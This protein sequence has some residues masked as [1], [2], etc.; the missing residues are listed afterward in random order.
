MHENKR[1]E[2]RLVYC[3]SRGLLSLKH[4]MK[5][6]SYTN[7]NRFVER[8]CS[9]SLMIDVNGLALTALSI[10]NSCAYTILFIVNKH[11]VCSQ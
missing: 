8:E 3:F 2:N 5:M 9:S 11:I 4:R 10:N 6:E 7:E 1:S